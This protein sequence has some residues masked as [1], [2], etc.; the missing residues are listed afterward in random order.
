MEGEGQVRDLL[1][2]D[3]TIKILSILIAVVLWYNVLD[4]NTTPLETTNINISLTVLNENSLTDKGMGLKDWNFQ[5]NIQL[6][7]KGRKD[8]IN[9]LGK[10]DFQAQIDLANIKNTGNNEIPVEIVTNKSD[11]TIDGVSPRKIKLNIENIVEK[12]FPIE[13][14][15][16]GSLAN[17]YEI[18]KTSVVPDTVSVKDFESVIK[19]I[20]SVRAV[21]DVN[22]LN[23]DMNVEQF[24]KLYNEKNEEIT[25]QQKD[26]TAIVK[27]EVAK[28]V[29]VV[30]DITGTPAKNYIYTENKVVP[31]TVLV[32]GQPEILNA[33]DELKTETVDLKNL[34]ASTELKK[35]LVVP[36]GLKVV[37]SPNEVS[38]SVTIEQLEIKSLTV[39][40]ED[41][42]I[43]AN[44]A[45]DTLNYEI[46]TQSITISLKGKANELKNINIDSI[47]PKI[48]VADLAEG[49][50]KLPLVLELPDDIK[51]EGSYEVE[52][53]VTKKT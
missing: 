3:I 30:T 29:N 24:C 10:N 5:R 41:I 39:A 20:S 36:A 22:N 25:S 14:K 31:G 23:R 1:R 51:T 19:S 33:I 44:A 37:R 4:K 17:N 18:I 32:S 13:V 2:K 12:T 6:T 28:E 27:I 53:I 15:P 8:K 21:V 40:K 38:V 45:D 26:I 34:K 47:K 9:S 48:N 52:V 46:Q 7:I 42:E 50:H 49:T 16:V 35:A 43:S 11:I